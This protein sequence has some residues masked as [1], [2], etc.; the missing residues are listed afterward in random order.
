MRPHLLVEISAHGFG[1]LAQTAPVVDTL[2]RQ[3]PQLRVTVRSGLPPALLRTRLTAPF[4]Y[5]QHDADI[6]MRMAS[7]VT[8]RVAASHAVYRLFHANWGDQVAREARALQEL[9]PDLILSNVPYRV[10]AAAARA[11]IPAVA[12]SSLNWAAIYRHYCTHLPGADIV[13]AQILEAYRAAQCFLR[14]EPALPMPDLEHCRAV[15]PIA[16]LGRRRRDE[17]WSAHQIHPTEHLVLIG[18]GGI[19]VDT[20][21]G[22]WPVIP[23]VRW[24]VPRGWSSSRVDLKPFADLSMPFIDML[25]SCDAVLSKPGY[26]TFVEA[27]CHGV[28]VLSIRRPD[29]PETPHLNSWL[30]AH[31]VLLEVDPEQVWAG[32]IELPLA[33]LLARPRPPRP[34]PGG[35]QEAAQLLASMLTG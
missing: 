12:L 19:N 21:V 13:H 17:L 7:P 35:A 20:P 2:F 24:L 6:G 25:A 16:A 18:L 10:L 11:G 27:A 32:E 15:G 28:P 9:A 34:S 31:G 4:Q 33:Q 29:W 3:L 26:G 23:G 8:V 1:H 22:R 14:I 5:S 30:N